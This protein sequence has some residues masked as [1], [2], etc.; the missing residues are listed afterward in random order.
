MDRCQQQCPEVFRRC[1]GTGGLRQLHAGDHR[2][3]GLDRT[4]LNTDYAEWAEH[5]HTVILPARV[6]KPRYKSSAENAVGILEKGIFHD[7]AEMDY[8]SLEQFNRYLWRHLDR[9]NSAPFTKKPPAVGTTGMRSGGSSCPC[10]RYLT[11]IWNGGRRRCLLTTMFALTM[12][13]TA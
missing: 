5:N 7:M 9:L 1:S 13:I 3:P 6:K 11:S 4:E 10:L 8:F 2:Q 12:P